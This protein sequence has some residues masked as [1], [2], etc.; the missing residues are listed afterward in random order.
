[1]A[2]VNLDPSLINKS[3]NEN[4]VLVVDFWAPWCGPCRAFGPVLEAVSDECEGVFAKVNVDEYQEFASQ[5][6]ISSIPTVW[7][8]KDGK[9]VY[10]QPGLVSKEM[11]KE[12]IK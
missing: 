4:S 12:L 7:V 6:S 1:M 2:V 3:A 8:F 10:D 9:K 5:N 11:L